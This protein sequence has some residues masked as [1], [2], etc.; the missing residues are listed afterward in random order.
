MT[1]VTT[2]DWI[3][4]SVASMH[5]VPNENVFS[6]LEPVIESVTVV[7]NKKLRING[8]SNC[9][10]VSKRQNARNSD[11]PYVLRP[12]NCDCI[13]NNRKRLYCKF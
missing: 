11:A 12:G 2:V 4:D 6:F 10:R 8:K 1:K 13:E 3:V 5:I 7:D 9:I